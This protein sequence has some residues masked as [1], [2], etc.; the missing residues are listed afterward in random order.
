MVRNTYIQN[1]PLD[2][3]IENFMVKLTANNYFQIETEYVDILEAGGRITSQAITAKRSSPHYIASAMDG[4]AVKAANTFYANETNPIRIKPEDYRDVDTGDYIPAEF[5]AVIMIED[6]NFINDEAEIIKPAVPWQH[7]RSVG[8]DLVAHDMIIP[9]FTYIGAHEIGSLLTAAVNIIPVVKKPRV[10]IIP[11]GTELIIR[12]S[13]DMAPGEIVESNSHMIAA[14]CKEWDTIP[15]QT[16][17]VIDD[18]TKLKEKILEVLPYCDMVV[19]CS[20]SSAGKEDYTSAIIAE[21]GEVLTHGLAIKPGKPAILGI[22]DDKPALGIPGYPV[23]AQLVFNLFARPILYKKQGINPPEE[24]AINCHV[25]RKLA[26]NMGVDEFIYANVAKIKDKYVA[27]PLSRGA[28][29][30]TSLVKADGYIHIDKSSEGLQANDE[31]KLILKNTPNISRNIID[32]TIV[33]IGS[34]DLTLD[35]LADIFSRKHIRLISNNVGSMGGLMALRREETHFSGIHLLDDETGEYNLS[36]VKKYL[37]NKNYLLVNL[38][39]REQGLIVSKNNPLNIKSLNDV[40]NNNY[41]FINRQKGSGTRILLDYLIKL[42]QFNEEEINGY[43]RE[44]YTHLAVAASVKNN[45][46]D[47]GLGIYA[48]AKA[49]DLSFIPI[50]EE[51]YDLCIL[52]DLLPKSQLDNILDIISSSEFKSRVLLYGGYNLNETGTIIYENIS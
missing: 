40:I 44:E 13:E 47:V 39:K 14:L 24:V 9:S 52:T 29:I 31:C 10:A 18:K 30:T 16:A 34:H 28:G 1:T 22:I 3:A 21:L 32:K 6:V 36:Y 41:R 49:M 25:S 48:A 15:I 50:T 23:S 37:A 12:G 8:E 19:I 4:I 38:V 35:Y 17:I 5:D 46:C 2:T 33:T 27:Y 43:N 7:I 42:H 11:T 20:G 45:A 51:R 26:S